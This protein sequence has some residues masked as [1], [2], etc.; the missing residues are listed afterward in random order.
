M[1]TLLIAKIPTH[2]T[3]EALK[4]LNLDNYTEFETGTHHATKDFESMK[5]A[6]NYLK[7]LDITKVKIKLLTRMEREKY[8]N[9]NYLKF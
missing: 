3:S 9:L 1:K 4:S 8:R 2:H 6:R 5:D 7:G